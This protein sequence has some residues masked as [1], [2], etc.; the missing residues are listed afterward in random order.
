MKVCSRG[1]EVRV[2][3]TESPLCI[4][5]AGEAYFRHDFNVSEGEATIDVFGCLFVLVLVG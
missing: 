5:D 3:R 4:E 1:L 2:W